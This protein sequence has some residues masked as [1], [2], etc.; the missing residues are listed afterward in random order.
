MKAMIPNLIRRFVKAWWR[1]ICG[2]PSD[3]GWE[4]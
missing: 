4:W 2:G 3:L 1:L